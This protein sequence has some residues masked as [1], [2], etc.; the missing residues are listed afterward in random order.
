MR[1]VKVESNDG[2]YV[3]GVD[4]GNGEYRQYRLTGIYDMR[5]DEYASVTP[6]QVVSVHFMDARDTIKQRIKELSGEQLA[7]IYGWLENTPVR[8][9]RQTG[10]VE[11][12]EQ[13]LTVVFAGVKLTRS[14]VEKLLKELDN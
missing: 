4:Q 7:T 2:A 10:C 13:E 6:T 8:W 3:T 5:V 9:N 12:D 11:Y 1:Q 14:Q